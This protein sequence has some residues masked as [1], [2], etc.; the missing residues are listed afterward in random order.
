MRVGEND[1][2]SLQCKDESIMAPMQIT[3]RFLSS[4][5]RICAF[6]DAHENPRICRVHSKCSPD[7]RLQILYS[8]AFVHCASTNQLS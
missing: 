5:Y 8:L 4:T 6:E 7:E 2:P 3:S 1:I